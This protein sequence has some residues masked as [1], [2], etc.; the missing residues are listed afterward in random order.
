MRK[1]TRRYRPIFGEKHMRYIRACRANMYNIAEG[2]IRAGKTVDNVFAFCTE[3][4]HTRDKLHLASAATLATAKLNLGD[5]NGLG[6]EAQFRGRCRWGKY[7][8]NECLKVKTRTGGMK[9]VIFVGAGKA[10]SFKRIRGNSYG[11]W[12]ATEINLHH[13]EFIKEAFNR[14]AAAQLRKFFWDLNPSSPKAKIYTDYIDAYREKHTRGKLPGG[15]NYEKFTL[16]DNATITPQR[17]EEIKAQ[18]TPGTVWYRRDIQGERCAVEG[19][20]YEAFAGDASPFTW[21]GNLPPMQLVQIGVDFG[22]NGS[23][24]SFTC[25]GFT[26]GFQQMIVLDEYYRREIISPA[27]LA[28]DFVAFVRRCQAR[29]PVYTCFADSAEQVLMEGLRAACITQGVVIDIQNARKGPIINRIR[30]VCQMMA[31][32]RFYLAPHC[33]HLASALADAIWDPK[34]IGEDVRLDDGAHNIDSLDSME[35]SCENMIEAMIVMG[36]TFPQRPPTDRAL[37][38]MNL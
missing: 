27:V 12:I 28:S 20:I 11:M 10:D 29:W 38:G 34:H 33:E 1:L 6:M 19:V 16:T 21:Q 37:K 22:S 23:A 2:A 15:C 25:T 26:Q 32:G 14:T 18:Y 8:G 7:K 13:D 17:V 5:C 35:Y 31:A 24:H 30:F 36:I 9:Y 3:L 4:E